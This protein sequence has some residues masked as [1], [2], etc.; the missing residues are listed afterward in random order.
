MQ[1]KFKRGD[2]VRFVQHPQH[3][4]SSGIMRDPGPLLVE[5][6][7][8]H[9]YPYLDASSIETGEDWRFVAEYDVNLDP[10]LTSFYKEKL[11]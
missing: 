11:K 3:I 10:F 8:A 5:K 1:S 2:I 6:V 7:S 4:F 9:L